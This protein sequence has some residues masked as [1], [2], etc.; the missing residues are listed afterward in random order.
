MFRRPFHA[1]RRALAQVSQPVVTQTQPL[2]VEPVKTRKP[3]GGFRG[4]IIGFLLGLTTTGVL[5]YTQLLQTH[6]DTSS[7]LLAT[8]EDLQRSTLSLTSH[9]QRIQTLE[10]QLKKLEQKVVTKDEVEEVRRDVRG[11]VEGVR[12]EVLEGREALSGLER[13]FAAMVR[14]RRTEL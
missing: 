9:I 1:S 6:H 3:I 13:D 8:V 7:T 14:R 2:V 12:S 11:M 5:G 4:G 10:T